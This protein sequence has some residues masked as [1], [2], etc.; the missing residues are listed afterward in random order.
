MREITNFIAI[1]GGFL[2]SGITAVL[3][4][5]FNFSIK[6]RSLTRLLLFPIAHFGS[7][8]RIRENPS[9]YPI[10][11]C[12]LI[13]VSGVAHL[14][15]PQNHCIYTIGWGLILLF[16]I[17]GVSV[18]AFNVKRIRAFLFCG[19]IAILFIGY[20]VLKTMQIKN[21]QIMNTI[22]FLESI[23]LFTGSV[24]ILV[25]IV[26]K[27]RFVQEFD[28]FLIF[29]GLV[30]YSFLHILSS[31]ILAID[32]VKYFDFALYATLITML[33]WVV[34]IPWIRRLKSKLS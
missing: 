29:F 13:F 26:V 34:I 5:Q 1:Y 7:I 11:L 4:Y 25:S 22:D 12:Y 8:L 28:A 33:Y 21:Y 16:E 20:G 27:N 15:F 14:L 30:I 24:Y 3:W 23:Y 31:G 9:V 6:P 18:Y 32:V 19:I 17:F 2:L 10:T